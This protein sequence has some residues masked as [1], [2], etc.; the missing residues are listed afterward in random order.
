MSASSR[1]SPASRPYTLTSSGPSSSWPSN[2]TTPSRCIDAGARSSTTTPR[3]LRA[4]RI[5]DTVGRP[6]GDPKARWTIAAA[7]T[8]NA[9]AADPP[10]GSAAPSMIAPTN[11][12]AI[13]QLAEVPERTGEMRRRRRHHRRGDDHQRGR[14]HGWSI[15]VEQQVGE[16]GPVVHDDRGR[17]RGAGDRQAGRHDQVTGKGQATAGDGGDEEHQRPHHRH[18]EHQPPQRVEEPGHV[19]HHARDGLLELGEQLRRQRR[20]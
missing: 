6:P 10:D 15:D 9:I 8:P 14:E 5:R 12:I 19:G 2:S 1:A 7:S 13:S 17:C 4:S 16:A 3:S 18:P 20:R 11:C